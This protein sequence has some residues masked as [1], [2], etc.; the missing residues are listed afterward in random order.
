[1][2]CSN[3]HAKIKKN[4]SFCQKCGKKI[5]KNIHTEEKS[6]T[7][8]IIVIVLVV[9]LIIGVAFFFIFYQRPTSTQV[10]L[11]NSENNVSSQTIVEGTENSILSENNTK[12]VITIESFAQCLVDKGVKMYGAYWCP[13]CENNKKLFG[14]SWKDEIYVECAIKDQQQLQTQVCIDAG[15]SGYPTW[16]INGKKYPG[17]QSL[18]SLSN[19]SGCEY[20]SGNSQTKIIDN[21]V[22]NLSESLPQLKNSV[23]TPFDRV[24]VNS[25]DWKDVYSALLYTG[26]LGKQ[27]GIFLTSSNQESLMYNIPKNVSGILLITSQSKS[28][29]DGYGQTLRSSGY[30]NV[31]E[32]ALDNINLNL[33]N[34]LVKQNNIKKFILVDDTY[35]YDAISS[36]PYAI[37]DQYYVLFVNKENIGVVDAFLSSVNPQ[38][39]IL[40]GQFSQDIRNTL[41]DYN[42][43][44]IGNENK[45]D[46]NI[47]M[48]KKFKTV[49]DTQQLIISS[50]E[51][52]ER[53]L[54]SVDPV[55]FITPTDVPQQVIDYVKQANFQVAVLIGNE[56]IDSLKIFREKTGISVFVKFAQGARNPEGNTSAVEDLD[57][58]II[59][60]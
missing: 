16:L 9:L 32:L 29:V 8:S 18:E 30:S 60:T 57:K 10:N 50:G 20:P 41:M 2:K 43:E 38:K 28:Y 39:I 44:V 33:A 19:M 26:L 1:M 49:N 59:K 17:E 31:N 21:A 56:L 34:I 35:G 54:F 11:N 12:K 27:P 3:C 42:P 37:V 23:A 40:L 36:A 15:I 47:V 6:E 55:I 22:E 51:F 48:V 53:S 24:I 58:F 4:D 25:E 13:H 45:F 5:E 46:N 7:L 52:I 14:A